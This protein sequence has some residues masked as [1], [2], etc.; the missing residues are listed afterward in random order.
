[1]R[2]FATSLTSLFKNMCGWL[3]LLT[4][5]LP[6]TFRFFSAAGICPIYPIPRSQKK[7]F[8]TYF[9]SLLFLNFIPR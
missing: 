5:N 3:I 2:S 8:F 7:V 1:M 4:F 9:G 6:A